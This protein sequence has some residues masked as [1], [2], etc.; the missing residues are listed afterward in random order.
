MKAMDCADYIVDYALE[1]NLKITNLQL[2]KALY[3]FA[4]EY[5]RLTDEYPYDEKILAWNYGPVI[6][7][8][9][10][11][12]KIYDSFDIKQISSHPTF[13]IETLNFN[14]KIY[15]ITDIDKTY[16]NI[17]ENYLKTFLKTPI[18]E[19]VE[20]TRKQKFYK[21]YEKIIY[22]TDSLSYPIQ[23]IH[24]NGMTLNQFLK[25]EENKMEYYVVNDSLIEEIEDLFYEKY[26]QSLISWEVDSLEYESG[27][28]ATLVF[29][30]CEV[31]L[32]GVSLGYKVYDIENFPYGDEPFKKLM[33]LLKT[34][35]KKNES[36]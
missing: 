5:I 19:I 4:V 20:F 10:E 28:L 33:E 34:K 21:K 1:H 13:N 24:L 30:D 25:M 23:E 11:E 31:Y 7:S 26:V 22:R 8:V 29:D 3:C 35:G 14:H 12:Y 9:Y 36:N 17:V 15:N 16:Q 18:F 2:Q 6:L 27:F 32:D